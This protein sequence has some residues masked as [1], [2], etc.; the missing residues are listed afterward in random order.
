M[1]AILNLMGSV[2]ILAGSVSY[3]QVPLSLPA[4]LVGRGRVVDQAKKDT[5][6]RQETEEL[7]NWIQ[8][9]SED[10]FVGNAK[11]GVS[12]MLGEAG[13][14]VPAEVVRSIPLTPVDA[15]LSGSSFLSSKAGTLLPNEFLQ[16]TL[17]FILEAPATGII[18]GETLRSESTAPPRL[19]QVGPVAGI[20]W[21]Q[22]DTADAN[23]MMEAY[24]RSSQ[25]AVNRSNGLI[26]VIS[27]ISACPVTLSAPA[28]SESSAVFSQGNCAGGVGPTQG[29]K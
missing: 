3:G 9:L 11:K 13:N 1:K 6:E 24:A 27:T 28:K 10:Q 7:F 15:W 18:V 8:D 12:E 17:P 25:L 19:D 14:A 23:S 4:E 21:R 2:I 5:Y 22:K 20:T 26:R 29:C 16:V